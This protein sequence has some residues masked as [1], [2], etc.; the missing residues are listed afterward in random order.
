MT[1]TD[2]DQPATAPAPAS[3]IRDAVRRTTR[4]DPDDTQ[5]ATH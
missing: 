5:D 2:R 3:T 4:R 1:G